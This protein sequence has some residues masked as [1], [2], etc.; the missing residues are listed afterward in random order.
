MQPAFWGTPLIEYKYID[1]N[2]G[3]ILEKK[4]WCGVFEDSETKESSFSKAIA[5]LNLTKSPPMWEKCTRFSNGWFRFFYPKHTSYKHGG[6]IEECR[7]LME[8]FVVYDIKPS[9]KE[10][11]LKEFTS[12]LQQGAS[13]RKLEQVVLSLNP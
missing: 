13:S 4:L 2:S 6:I 11:I 10:K 12:L 7:L 1:I 3:R 8:S 9:R 5:Q